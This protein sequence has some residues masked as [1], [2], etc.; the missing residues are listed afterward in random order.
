MELIQSTSN[1]GAFGSIHLFLHERAEL[2]VFLVEY[3]MYSTRARLR[4]GDALFAEGFSQ[5]FRATEENSYSGAIEK[6]KKISAF[7]ISWTTKE[8]G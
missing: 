7:G 8:V 3:E 1:I 6:E 2:E 4:V 5:G